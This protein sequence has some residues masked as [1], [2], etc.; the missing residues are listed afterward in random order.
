MTKVLLREALARS[1][2]RAA[3][4]VADAVGIQSIRDYAKLLGIRSKISKNLAIALGSEAITMAELAN[5]YAVFAS[6]GGYAEL[7]F[8]TK[9]ENAGG[10]VDPHVAP[11]LKEVISPEQAYL[12]TNLMRSVIEARYGTAGRLRRLGRPAAGKTGTTNK[13]TNAWFVGFT[14]QLL[15]SV[16]VGHDDRK[17]I[18]RAETGGRSAA[19]IWLDFMKAAHMNLPKLD[20]KA[21]LGI[22]FV[23]IDPKTGLK[24]Q[25]TLKGAVKEA[26]LANTAPTQMAR[27]KGDKDPESFLMDEVD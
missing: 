26:F 5:A 15:A 27:A 4:Q 24:A 12:I 11:T 13:N 10:V 18:G 9:I 23:S 7:R 25:A 20:F 1:L 22:E 3:L 21:P 19:P 16:W 6:G 17:S 2:N 8:I 14:P